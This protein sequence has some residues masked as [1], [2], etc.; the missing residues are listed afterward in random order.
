MYLADGNS[1]KTVKMCEIKYFACFLSIIGTTLVGVR[2]DNTLNCVP[3][4][5]LGG[6]EDVKTLLQ[7][8]ESEALFLLQET[9]FSPVV[10]KSDE[11]YFQ[12]SPGN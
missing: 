9:V 11:N 2:C 4:A 7:N 10:L 6:G 1:G 5:R 8:V 12:C 3:S